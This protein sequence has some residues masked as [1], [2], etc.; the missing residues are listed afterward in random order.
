M[1]RID[2]AR[3]YLATSK[4]SIEAIAEKAGFLDHERMRRSF[5]RQLGVN[6]KSYRERFTHS[7]SRQI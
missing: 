4:L 3:H 2:T 6:P 7:S 1:A 5:I